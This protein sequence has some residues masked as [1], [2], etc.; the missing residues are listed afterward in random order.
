MARSPRGKTTSESNTITL[1]PIQQLAAAVTLICALA[2]AQAEAP[3]QALSAFD[4]I[5]YQKGQAFDRMLESYLGEATFRDGLRGYMAKHPVAKM[6]ADWTMQPGF[7]LI[8]VEQYCANGKRL[9]ALSQEQ[10]RVDEPAT[11]N[12]SGRP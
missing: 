10:F 1:R 12:R 7:P 8:K 5:A 9:L 2:P 6:V 3:D 11:E 4:A